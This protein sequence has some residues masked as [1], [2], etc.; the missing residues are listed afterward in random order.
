MVQVSYTGS[1]VRGT[2]NKPKYYF[3]KEHQASLYSYLRSAPGLFQETQ[4]FM[5]KNCY[6]TG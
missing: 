3:N 6:S 1:S 4:G 5:P 2:L